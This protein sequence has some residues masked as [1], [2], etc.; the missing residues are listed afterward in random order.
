MMSMVWAQ[1]SEDNFYYNGFDGWSPTTEQ[2]DII[3][4]EVVDPNDWVLKRVLRM[5]DLDQ[6]TNLSDASALE[7][8]KFIINT[9]LALTSLVALVIIIYGFGQIIFAKDDEGIS[10]ARQTVQWAAIAIAI[11]A[12]SRFL[13]TFLFSIYN[14]VQWI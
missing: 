14:A 7:Y 10:T 3:K 11:L 5:F 1:S 2:R 9:A 13:V 12:L 4:A 8:I 6:Y